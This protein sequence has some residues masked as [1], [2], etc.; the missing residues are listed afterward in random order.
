MSN[1]LE[2]IIKEAAVL[3][4]AVLSMNLPGQTEKNQENWCPY[5]DWKRRPPHPSL[6]NTEL[7]FEP[8]CSVNPWKILLTT[9]SLMSQSLGATLENHLR[10]MLLRIHRKMNQTR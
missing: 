5:S 10:T 7:T 8:T 9:R 1:E 3:W 6:P 2:M 4:F